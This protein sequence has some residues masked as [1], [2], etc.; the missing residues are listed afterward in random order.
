M[1]APRCSWHSFFGVPALTAL[2]G[3]IV[4]NRPAVLEA[5]R[6]AFLAEVEGHLE[7]GFSELGHRDPGQAIHVVQRGP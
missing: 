4:A 6:Q 2:V 5:Q 7:E 1:R 3:H